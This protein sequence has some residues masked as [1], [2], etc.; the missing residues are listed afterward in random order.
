[1]QPFDSASLDRGVGHPPRHE[2]E[3]TG[4]GWNLAV[5]KLE[6]GVAL[7]DVERLIGVRVDVERRPRLTWRARADDD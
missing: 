5:S 1:M 7:G 6:R 3:A 4:G 2:D